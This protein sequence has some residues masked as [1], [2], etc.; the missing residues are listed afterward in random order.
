MTAYAT[1]ILGDDPDLGQDAVSDTLI[2]ATELLPRFVLRADLPRVPAAE[3]HRRAVIMWLFRINHRCAHRLRRVEIRERGAS[4]SSIDG[5][6]S[7]NGNGSDT[8]LERFEAPGQNGVPARSLEDSVIDRTVALQLVDVA[9]GLTDRQRSAILGRLEGAPDAATAAVF[10]VS[11]N[12]I[13]AEISKAIRQ[14][15]C[16]LVERPDLVRDLA[17]DISP[18]LLAG[19]RALAAESED[20]VSDETEESEE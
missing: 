7:G 14:V 15:R 19:L 16:G 11:E 20:E 9:P 17:G 8:G 4:F 12:V 3:Q 5:N 6:G 1:R 2:R 18:A 13:R 10:G